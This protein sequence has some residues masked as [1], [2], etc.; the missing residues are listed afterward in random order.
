VKASTILRRCSYNQF[1]WL[2]PNFVG[3]D[4]TH[5]AT[6]ACPQALK[7]MLGVIFVSLAS[8]SLAVAHP[9]SQ[10]FIPAQVSTV[11]ANLDNN[12][13]GL[14]VVPKGF[15]GTVLHAGQLLVSNFNDS[16]GTQGNGSTIVIINPATGQ[17]TG[18][19]FQGTL[20]A[21]PALEGQPP[22]FT[23]ALGIVKEGFVFAGSV[24]SAPASGGLLVIDSSGKLVTQIQEGTNGPWG[25]AINNQGKNAAQLFVS[26]V[27]DGTVT[28]ISV[29]FKGGFK[30]VGSPTT[31][32]SGYSF[33]PDS[34]GLVVGPAGLAYDSS[35]DILYVASEDDN[36][37]FAIDNASTL[38]SPVVKG[39]LIFSDP[40]LHGPL[41]LM[42][43]PNGDLVTAN[44]DPKAHID[45]NEPSELVE[46]TKSGN[47]VREF[48]IDPNP[49]SAF[50]I[51]N[52][53]TG[54]ANQFAYVDDFT[55]VVDIARFAK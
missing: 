47:L 32:A 17:Q 53:A 23:N 52:V 22:G 20:Q 27:L 30:T 42:I 3:V 21:P 43:A 24:T 28:R 6:R 33:G 45:D 34:L 4:T 41:G 8:G 49:G 38:S 50:A 39:S 12:P 36:Q 51:L 31:I 5:R 46:F 2:K 48:S 10:P 14:A 25:L 40:S 37:I 55:F 7:I 26:N 35:K 13:Y 19:F 44:A 15:P 54:G 16:G 9:K 18:V 29:S 1:Q 11:P